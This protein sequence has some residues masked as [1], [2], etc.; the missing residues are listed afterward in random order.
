MALPHQL[1]KISAAISKRSWIALEA[2]CPK[3]KLIAKLCSA[4]SCNGARNKWNEDGNATEPLVRA[5]RTR[6]VCKRSKPDASFDHKFDDLRR[7]WIE[8]RAARWPCTDLSCEVRHCRCPIPS[9]RP[10]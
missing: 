9:R 4:S 2:V 7:F 3:A 5:R 6:T 8:R 1:K 10:E